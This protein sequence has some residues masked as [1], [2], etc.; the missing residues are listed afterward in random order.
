MSA[1][2]AEAGAPVRGAPRREITPGA[3]LP[4]LGFLLLAALFPFLP[5]GTRSEFLLQIAFFTLVAG[6][7]ALSWDILARSGQVSLSHAAFYGLGAYSYALLMRAGLPW[8]A[9]MPLAAPEHR[10]ITRK[11]RI[12]CVV[13]MKFMAAF[14]SSTA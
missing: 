2:Q 12:P 8:P 5:L 10:P 4:L 13:S 3:A 9:A 11:R 14:R 7:M 6:I 1:R